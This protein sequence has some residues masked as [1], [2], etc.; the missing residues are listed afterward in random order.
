MSTRLI[1]TGRVLERAL[2]RRA[3]IMIKDAEAVPAAVLMPLWDKED[4]VQVVFTKRNA[5]L[6]HHAGQVS[7]P[8][9]SREPEDSNLVDTALRETHEEIGVKAG[10]VSVVARLDQVRTATSNFVVTPFLGILDDE[11]RFKP[12]PVEVERLVIIPLAKVLDT[13]NY[14][15][16]RGDHAK[17]GA[18][19]NSSQP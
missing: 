9:G 5:R 19:G 13:A 12:S 15:P 7:F 3:P 8:G 14:P 4:G 18:L 11:T 10:Q 16:H 2:G 6:P 17:R 1:E